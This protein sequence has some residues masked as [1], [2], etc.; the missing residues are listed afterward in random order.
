MISAMRL[1]QEIPSFYHVHC[2]EQLESTNT[3]L[4]E[5][6]E[7]EEGT[8]IIADAQ[9]GGK[10][11]NGHS[12][13]SP[14]GSGI[15]L[16]LLLKPDGSDVLSLTA[17]ASVACL[18]AIEEVYG[19]SCSIKWLNDV[20]FDGKKIAG[21]LCE[22]KMMA[23]CE[24]MQA[25]VVGIGINVHAFEKPDDIADIAGS[26]EDFANI[27]KP[28]QMLVARFLNH[29][30]ALYKCR[31]YSMHEYYRNHSCVIGKVV[32]VIHGNAKY[33]AFAMDV[34]EQYR[35]VL[36]KEDGTYDY[37]SSGEVSIRL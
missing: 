7:M 1:Q 27:R 29:F 19:L 20:M 9:T 30:Y 11:R 36:R 21:I 13:H 14:K 26:I 18:K 23:G 34:D 2:F 32:T 3:F 25:M 33:R 12:F 31:D 8:V 4:M 28:R 35:L 22:G 16:S 15:Y 6:S 17:A 5:H 10:G 24:N 37:L